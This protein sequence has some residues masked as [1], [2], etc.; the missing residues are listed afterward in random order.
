[1]VEVDEMNDD[2]QHSSIGEILSRQEVRIL[3]LERTNKRLK[4]LMLFSCAAVFVLTLVGWSNLQEYA[5]YHGQLFIRDQVGTI[6]GMVGYD[7]ESNH[8]K[9]I[10]GTVGKNTKNGFVFNQKISLTLDEVGDPNIDLYS[11][12]GLHMLKLGMGA[13]PMLSLYDTDGDIAS[14][15]DINGLT[16]YDSSPDSTRYWFFGRN[17][18]DEGVFGNEQ[19]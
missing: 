1:M 16:F 10:I 7:P 18:Y 12:S 8:G 14:S 19:E 9:I 13:G 15:L 3:N 2:V 4:W 17:G 5:D 6:R 11:N